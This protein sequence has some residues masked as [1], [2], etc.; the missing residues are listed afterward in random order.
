MYARAVQC[1]LNLPCTRFFLSLHAM[2]SSPRPPPTALTRPRSRFVETDVSSSQ[3]S[4]SISSNVDARHRSRL[5]SPRPH[6]SGSAKA[7]TDQKDKVEKRVDKQS[8]ENWK[9]GLVPTS[10]AHRSSETDEG[11]QIREPKGRHYKAWPGVP[12]LQ[13]PLKGNG[14]W[15]PPGKDAT[16]W[17][18]LFYGELTFP[19]VA[20]D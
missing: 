19:N 2:S 17:I 9:R 18:N 7:A 11:S 10:I 8:S 20:A 5:T 1:D 6:E 15:L 3:A 13:Q 12:Y 4:S 16:H 14:S